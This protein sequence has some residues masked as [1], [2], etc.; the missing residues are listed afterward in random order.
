VGY[1]H[2]WRNVPSK[3]NEQA[4]EVAKDILRRYAGIVRVHLM[5]DDII[6]FNGIGEDEFELFEFKINQKFEFCKTARRPYDIA[7]CEVLL[8]M[9]YYLP[10]LTIS[11]DAYEI[12]GALDESWYLAMQNLERYGVSFAGDDPVLD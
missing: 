1:T 12:G 5:S 8:V 9:K 7:V 6:S 3:L 4:V 2:Y 10:T 11:S